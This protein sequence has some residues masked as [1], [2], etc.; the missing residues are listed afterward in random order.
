[1]MRNLALAFT[2]LAFTGSAFAADMPVPVRKAPPAPAYY[3]PTWTGCSFGANA[4]GIFE[5]TT[6]HRTA[7]GAVPLNDN[8][9]SQS[10]ASG[11]VGGQIGCDYQAGNWVFGAQGLMDATFLKGSNPIPPFPTFTLRDRTPWYATTTARVGYTV[12]PSVL[13]YGKG[14]AAFV[15]NELSVYGPNGGLSETAKSDKVGWTAG[16][17][18]EW[19]YIPNVSVFLEYQHLD[20]G[21]KS[22]AFTTA[23]G[24]IGA[25]DV[26][27]SKQHFDTVMTGLNFHFK[28]WP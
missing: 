2:A 17:G 20:F 24:A 6:F 28:P 12:T 10:P 8:F 13:L 14:G 5:H 23:P 15:R 21:S 16:G 3:V 1:M 22:N 27:A 26:V 18:V 4:G 19:M 25:P 9:G 11:A 7:Q